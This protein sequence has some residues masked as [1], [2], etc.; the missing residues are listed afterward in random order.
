MIKDYFALALKN[1][2]K[3]GIRSWLTLIG[4]LIGV[5]AVISLISLGNGLKA[6]V[7]SQFN[8]GSTEVLTVQAGGISG[9][10]P[11]GSGAVKPLTE[12]DARAI[13]KISSVQVSIAREV[14]S[15]KL[16]YN[17]KAAFTYAAT[18]PDNLQQDNY[19]YKIADLKMQSGKLIYQGDRGVIVIGSNLADSTKNQL[20]RDLKV[21][22]KVQIN[23]GDF[24]VQ[25]IL[26]KQGSFIVD[27]AILM[28]EKDLQELLGYGD[29]VDIIEVKVADESLMNQTQNAIENLMRQR[30]DVKAGQEDFQV[31]TP[32]A[33]LNSVNQ[34]LFGI[35]IFIIIIASISIFVGAIGITNTMMTSVMERKREIGIMKSI[36]ARNDQIFY[37]FF[38]EAGLLGLIGGV[39]G[40]ILGTGIGYV[41]TAALNAF[42]GSSAQPQISFFLLFFTALGSFTIGSAAGIIPAIRASHE[43][44]VEDIRA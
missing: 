20:G 18:V 25:G 15:V 40:I 13:G 21:G 34:I 3:R 36:G 32:Q 1:L 10:G 8:I 19:L 12:D 9:Y 30:R 44:P 17:N 6:A 26:E 2:K 41:G 35:Q 42:I 38:I 27:N 4:I 22:D 24:K 11:P 43:R 5:A 16:I 31:T 33:S 14:R 28:N 37:Q 7:N 39:L 29:Q 23:G